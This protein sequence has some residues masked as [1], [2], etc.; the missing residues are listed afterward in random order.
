MLA[1]LCIVD[2]YFCYIESFITNAYVEELCPFEFS[3]EK[4]GLAVTQFC[5]LLINVMRSYFMYHNVYKVWFIE[6]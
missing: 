4:I 5:M 3:H 2:R 1:Q 6:A